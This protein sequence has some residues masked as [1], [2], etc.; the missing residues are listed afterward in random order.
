VSA[1]VAMRRLFLALALG[2]LT[3]PGL[4]AQT[5]PGPAAVWRRGIRRGDTLISLAC[6][7]LTDPR[8]WRTVARL[9][10][11]AAAGVLLVSM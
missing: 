6:A 7:S 9:T 10:P 2:A 11:P 5:A 1:L 8:E 4:C 3:P